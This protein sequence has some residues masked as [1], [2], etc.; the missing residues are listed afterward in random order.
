M[1]SRNAISASSGRPQ[2][3]L[4]QRHRLVAF[5][6]RGHGGSEKPLEAHFYRKSEAWADDVATVIE[7]KKLKR[8]VLVGWSLG[9]RVLRQYLIHHGDKRL[10]GINFLSCRPIEHP[11]SV[12]PGSAAMAKSDASDLRPRLEAEIQF[13]LDCFE[14]KPDE[15]DLLRTVA[16]NMIIPRPVRDAIAGWSTDPELTKAALGKVTVPTLVTHGRRDR[17]ILPVAAEMT[18]AAVKHARLS[19]YDECGHSPFYEDAPRY[20]RELD[21]FVTES[22]RAA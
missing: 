2:S 15:R 19:W 10:S 14:I 21:R 7:A 3:D 11:S 9:G 12:G 16:Y 8:P 4:A 5:D 18:A 13:L 6:L 20:N 22:W 1:A 17:L